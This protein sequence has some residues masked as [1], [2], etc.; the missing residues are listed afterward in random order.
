MNHGYLENVFASRRRLS[1][2]SLIK[3]T[4]ITYH[5]SVIKICSNRTKDLCF[6]VMMAAHHGGLRTA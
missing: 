1:F 2:F 3:T 4:N 5:F 6:G